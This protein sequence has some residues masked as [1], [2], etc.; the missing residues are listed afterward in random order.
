MN[1]TS[2]ASKTL[3]GYT[4]TNLNFSVNEYTIVFHKAEIHYIVTVIN[5]PVFYIVFKFIMHAHG[6]SY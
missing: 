5:S 4:L 6:D 2:Y 3:T 1:N